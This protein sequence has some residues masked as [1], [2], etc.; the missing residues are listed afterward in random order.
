[1]T[2]ANILRTFDDVSIRLF[3]IVVLMGL[4]FVAFATVAQSIQV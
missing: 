2:T 1:M 4:G 3:N